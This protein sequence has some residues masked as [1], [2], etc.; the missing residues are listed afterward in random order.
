MHTL[1]PRC[2]T[3]WIYCGV[4]GGCNNG[5]DQ[6]YDYA[7]CGLRHQDVPPSQLNG[8]ALGGGV[9]G[10]QHS[11]S[12]AL[13]LLPLPHHCAAY[14]SRQHAF[15]VAVACSNAASTIAFWSRGTANI[16][17]YPPGYTVRG[18]CL[19]LLDWRK[20]KAGVG[21]FVLHSVHS[22][23][24]Q[25]VHNRSPVSCAGALDVRLCAAPH[26]QRLF[27]KC[28]RHRWRDCRRCGCCLVGGRWVGG[29][30]GGWA[31]WRGLEPDR[32]FRPEMVA[33]RPRFQ[34]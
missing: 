22:S 31:R 6:V 27:I 16:T 9:L 4:D 21:V 20:C 32:C 14:H 29:Q 8:G 30:M 12:K 17:E 25:L 3:V 13:H 1:L 2:S 10:A 19:F 26:Q 34:L 23:C 11:C 7:S 28:G 24:L 33:A 18:L 5:Y 15:P